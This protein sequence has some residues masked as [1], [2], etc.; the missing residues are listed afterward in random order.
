[1]LH[2][3]QVCNIQVSMSFG[4]SGSRYWRE[5]LVDLTGLRKSDA[6]GNFMLRRGSRVRIN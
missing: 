4:Q 6:A 1:M 2:H 5:L 3:A